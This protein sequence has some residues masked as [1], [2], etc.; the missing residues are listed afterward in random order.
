MVKTFHISTIF[1]WWQNTAPPPYSPPIFLGLSICR[2]FKAKEIALTNTTEEN[3]A[4][5]VVFVYQVTI[6]VL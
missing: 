6:N 3:I 2:S 5:G 4:K 1:A